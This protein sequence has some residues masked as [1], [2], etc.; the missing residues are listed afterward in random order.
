[1]VFSHSRPRS[2]HFGTNPLHVSLLCMLAVRIESQLLSVRCF[3]IG[4]NTLRR[5]TCVDS[6]I[7]LVLFL[8]PRP[9]LFKHRL[10]PHFDSAYRLGRSALVQSARRES[11]WGLHLVA[12]LTYSWPIFASLESG[13]TFRQATLYTSHSSCPHLSNLLS[14]IRGCFQLPRRVAFTQ[15]SSPFFCWGKGY[16]QSRL[17]DGSSLRSLR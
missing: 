9:F 6:C 7:R 16:I 4:P 5:T 1:M 17:S 13:W 12:T 15:A 10:L 3:V 14:H 2:M 8:W 11:S